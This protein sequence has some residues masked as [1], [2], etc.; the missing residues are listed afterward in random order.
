LITPLQARFLPR[1]VKTASERLD[2]CRA[3]LDRRDDSATPSKLREEL[4]ALAGEAAMMG[5][6]ELGDAAR[7]GEHAARRLAEGGDASE[8]VAVARAVRQT[9]RK[10]RGLEAQAA[11]PAPAPRE[12][13]PAAPGAVVLVDDSE[14]NLDVLTDAFEREDIPTRGVTDE[15]GLREALAAGRPALVLTDVHMPSLT[16]ADVVAIV[17]GAHPGTPVYLVSGMDEAA[18]SGLVSE[19]GADGYA[20]KQ[21]GVEAVV[22]IARAAME[23]V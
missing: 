22:A 18:L 12:A 19:S 20:S 14:V 10:L 23:A 6:G 17:R 8:L 1:F 2:R 4:H 11:A 9:R 16:V 15:A 13:K 3:L 5:F 7:E 21:G